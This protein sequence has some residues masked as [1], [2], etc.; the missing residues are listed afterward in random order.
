MPM[1]WNPYFDELEQSGCIG[2]GTPDPMATKYFEEFNLCFDP[3]FFIFKPHTALTEKW[4]GLLLQKMDEKLHLL[5]KFPAKH[6]YESDFNLPLN[7]RQ[8]NYPLHWVEIMAD[9]IHPLCIEFKDE[10]LMTFYPLRT[11]TSEYR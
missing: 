2:I 1:D 8:E 9:N 3:A 6:P 5:K 4:Y 7:E 11:H 10:L